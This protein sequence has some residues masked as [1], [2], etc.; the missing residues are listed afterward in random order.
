MNGS[1]LAARGVLGTSKDTM[2]VVAAKIAE[3]ISI[4][5]GQP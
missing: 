2:A 1:A 3:L 4:W 5:S